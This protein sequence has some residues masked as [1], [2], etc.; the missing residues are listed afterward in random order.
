[1]TYSCRWIFA[2][3]LSSSHNFIPTWNSKFWSLPL[4][5]LP[6]RQYFV[7]WK[8]FWI[9]LCKFLIFKDYWSLTCS[10]ESHDSHTFAYFEITCLFDKQKLLDTLKYISFRFPLEF[11][12][13]SEHQNLIKMSVI[14]APGLSLAWWT[15]RSE[16][17]CI[18]LS[19]LWWLGTESV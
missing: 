12:Y 7:L 10:G 4:W 15:R 11:Y 1:M 16:L 3:F 13:Y 14:E 6:H 5:I 2:I 18:G 17:Y 8:T 9:W 19:M